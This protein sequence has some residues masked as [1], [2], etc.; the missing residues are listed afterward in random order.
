[1]VRI[2][3]Q[4][5]LDAN[6]FETVVV[7]RTPVNEIAK[8]LEGLDVRV[9]TAPK[10]PRGMGHSIAAGI[11]ACREN[12]D[13]YLIALADMP[14]ISPATFVALM[15]EGRREAIVAPSFRSVRGHPVLFGGRFREPL[16]ELTGDRGARDLLSRFADDFR[17]VKVDD[18]GVLRDYD[19]PEDFLS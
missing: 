11:A 7:A 13:G 15:K 16:L 14:A 18:P 8:A 19:R 4:N 2:S 17:T 9:I 6:P 12:A 1:M 5:L 10:S 3:A